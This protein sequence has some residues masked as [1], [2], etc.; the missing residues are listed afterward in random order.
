MSQHIVKK[1]AKKTQPTVDNKKGSLIPL[2]VC[3]LCIACIVGAV[4]YVKPQL[5]S[6]PF[7]NKS[8]QPPPSSPAKSST[9]SQKK[10]LLFTKEELAK[11]DDSNANL[12]VYL[13]ILG[14]VFDVSTGHYYKRKGGYHFFT[15]KDGTRAFVTG[16]FNEKGLIPDIEGLT[17]QQVLSI[18]EWAKFYHKDYT[19]VGKLIGHYYD[20]E[21]RPTEAHSKAQ[22]LIAKGLADKEEEERKK[23]EY[24]VCNSKWSQTEGKTLWCSDESG[25]IKRSWTGYLRRLY[26]GT[27]KERCACV[28]ESQFNDPNLKEFENCGAKTSSCHWPA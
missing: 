23:Q 8:P 6:F 15:G 2:A 1:E 17:P 25:G 9:D 12:P 27:D 26:P 19:Y 5:D 28:Q 10:E 21:G 11:Y 18:D 7:M 24:P 3:V 20:E 13:A 22:A 16:E 4:V 14:E